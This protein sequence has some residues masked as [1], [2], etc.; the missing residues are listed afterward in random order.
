MPNCEPIF[1]PWHFHVSCPVRASCVLNTWAQPPSVC[2]CFCL[3][4]AAARQCELPCAAPSPPPA[5]RSRLPSPPKSDRRCLNDLHSSSS[6]SSSS[7]SLSPP[8]RRPPCL[9]SCFFE[10]AQRTT[11]PL[12]QSD[13]LRG[14][15][16]YHAPTISSHFEVGGLTVGHC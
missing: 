11:R 7:S 6:S 14:G 5:L 15:R 2:C 13:F 12:T 16:E 4:A 3:S 8:A 10:A 9:C 1:Q